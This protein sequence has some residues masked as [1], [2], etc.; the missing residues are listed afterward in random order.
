MKKN[1]ACIVFICV[2]IISIS[3]TYANPGEGQLPPVR[4]I[5]PYEPI[6][7]LSRHCEEFAP[8]HCEES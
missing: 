2:L 3:L 8:R 6:G 1:L 4:P 5:D 7:S